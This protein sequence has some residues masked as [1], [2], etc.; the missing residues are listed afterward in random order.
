MYL[1]DS[2][3]AVDLEAVGGERGQAGHRHVG[4]GEGVRARRESNRGTAG[5]TTHPDN[6]SDSN[7]LF[8]MEGVR[9]WKE[10]N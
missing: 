7:K 3:L 5:H 9:A 8:V 1:R 2:I 4:D 10:S 6:Q